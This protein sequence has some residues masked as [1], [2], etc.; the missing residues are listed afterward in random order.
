MEEGIFVNRKITE[1]SVLIGWLSCNQA[2]G[3]DDFF[4][5]TVVSS[6]NEI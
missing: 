3:F 5:I 4:A 1:N 6:C 2:V